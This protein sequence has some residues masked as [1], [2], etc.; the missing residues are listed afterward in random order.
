MHMTTKYE[1]SISNPVVGE[2]CTDDDDA[3][4]TNAN[5]DRQSMIVHSVPHNSNSLISNYRLF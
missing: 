2:V 3:N 1:V 5:D 4:N